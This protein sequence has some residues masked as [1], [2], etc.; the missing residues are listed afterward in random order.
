MYSDTQIREV[1]HFC[2][3]DRLLKISDPSIYVLKGG[4]NLRFFF[5]SPRYSED[6]DIDVLAGDV[7][8]LKKNGYKIL[9]DAAFRRSLRVFD[10]DDIE[11]NDPGKAKQTKTTQRFRFGLIT[12]TGQRLPT[13]VEFSR[14][15]Q[16]TSDDAVV[17]LIDPDIALQYRKLAF[18]CQHY[19]GGV[20]IVQKVKALAGRAVTQA[21][22]VFDLAILYRG[23]NTPSA[24]LQQL[25]PGQELTQAIDC[26]MSLSWEDYQGQVLEFLDTNSRDEYGDKKAWEWLQTFVLESIEA[27]D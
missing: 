6:M 22:D 19:G 18:R 7:A 1:F 2:F 10:I 23:G 21:R 12:P 4:V 20:A 27:S 15:A 24:P 11:I 13:K 9:K 17:E 8:T 3:L 14:R 5:N 26:L 16:G 25:M